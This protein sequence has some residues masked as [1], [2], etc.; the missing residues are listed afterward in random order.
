MSVL[1]KKQMREVEEAEAK[2][3]SLIADIVPLLG[4]IPEDCLPEVSSHL[5][6]AL[7]AAKTSVS[8]SETK[9]RERKEEA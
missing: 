1:T 2:A 8:K 4:S 5:Q 6:K 3:R 9:V 7:E